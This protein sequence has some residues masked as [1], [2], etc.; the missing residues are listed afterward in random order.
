MIKKE[1]RGAAKEEESMVG[2]EAEV[3]SE[4]DREGKDSEGG[5]LRTAG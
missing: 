5:E 2:R 4:C 3:E 1:E